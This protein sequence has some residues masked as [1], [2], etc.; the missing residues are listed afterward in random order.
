MENYFGVN[1]MVHRKGATLATEDT[2]GIIPGSM[3][4]NSYIVKGKG[5][6]ESFNSCSHGA[7]RCMGRGQAIKSL[8]LEK[9]LKY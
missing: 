1:Y 9:K 6:P 7:G 2:I 5:N 3:G 8:N 4:S